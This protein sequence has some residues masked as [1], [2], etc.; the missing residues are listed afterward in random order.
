MSDMYFL[1]NSA[2]CSIQ[3]GGLEEWRGGIGVGG[4][5]QQIK[6]VKHDKNYLL[7]IIKYFVLSVVG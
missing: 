1:F 6:S 2:W 7:M 5:T 3:L 4:V